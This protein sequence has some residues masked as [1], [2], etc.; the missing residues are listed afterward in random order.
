MLYIYYV[1]TVKKYNSTYLPESS[2]IGL[3]DLPVQEQFQIKPQEVLEIPLGYSL[4]LAK[5][6]ILDVIVCGDLRRKGIRLSEGRYIHTPAH[7]QDVV[8]TIS[9]I[10]T[11]TETVD[12]EAGEHA[13]HA[14]PL[15]ISLNST[16]SY[17]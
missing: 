17:D 3:I 16:I 1:I 12:I 15:T 11:S 5:G 2:E 10:N 6:L 14:I 13:F 9:I 7:K 4:H 8:V